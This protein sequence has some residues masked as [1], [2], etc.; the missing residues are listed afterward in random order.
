MNIRAQALR[1][2]AV[3]VERGWTTKTMARDAMDR[4]TASMSPDAAK[5]CMA[6]AIS[7]AATE[8]L[9]NE[10]PLVIAVHLGNPDTLTPNVLGQVDLMQIGDFNDA[11]GRTAHIVAAALRRA[12][13]Y[14]EKEGT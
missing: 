3:L 14:A 11:P 7:R 13:E 4:P 1:A 12:A 10:W 5:W 8:Y 6:G 9:I 2:A